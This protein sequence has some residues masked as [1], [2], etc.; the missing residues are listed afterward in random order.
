MRHGPG[1]KNSSRGTVAKASITTREFT[2]AV[3]RN[4]SAYQCRACS[5]DLFI[6]HASRRRGCQK[7]L[8]TGSL[9]IGT[10]PPHILMPAHEPFPDEREISRVKKFS[11][12][13]WQNL[14]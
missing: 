14:A 5:V 6:Y 9:E 3:K 4:S 12:T 11:L 8:E 13:A 10:P 1:P 7:P 2:L